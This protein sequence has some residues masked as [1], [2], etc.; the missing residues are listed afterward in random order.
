MVGRGSFRTMDRVAS[1]RGRPKRGVEPRLDRLEG[2]TLMATWINQGPAP[3]FDG[4]DEG[5]VGTGSAANP[6][7]PVSGAV[8]AVAAQPGD[9]N[10]VYVGTTNGGIWKTTNAKATSPTWTPLTDDQISLSTGDIEFSPVDATHQTL[11]VGTG[12]F[13]SD[14]RDGTPG[15]GLLKTTD[16]GTTWTNINP[17]GVFN[18]RFIKS[19]V[20]TSLSGGDVLLVGTFYDGGGVYRSTDGGASFARLSGNGTS[21]LPSAGV[22]ILVPDAFNPSVFYAGVPNSGVYRSDDGGA[23]WAAR[24]VGIAN[25][26]TSNSRVEIT[27]SPAQSGVVFAAILNNGFPR[28]F[29]RSTNSGNTW[30]AMDLAGTNEP[31][32]FEGTNPEGEEGAEEAEMNGD[33]PGG[34]GSIHFAL[35]ADRSNAFVVYASGDRQPDPFPNSVGA[36]NYSGR[37]FRGDA[38]QPL[39]QSKQW[40]AVTNNGANPSGVTAGTSPHADSRD[41]V[42]DADGNILQGNDGGIYRLVN[43]GGTASTRGWTSVVGNLRNTEFISTAYSSLTHTVIGGAQDTGTP[44]QVSTDPN[45]AWSDLLQGDGGVVGVDDLS[46]ANRSIRYTSFQNFGFFNRTTWNASNTLLSQTQVA[47]R[48]P[49]QGN[50]TLFQVDGNIR[51]YQPFELNAIDPTRLVI[52]TANLYESTN[53]GDALTDRTG[54]TG[55]FINGVVYGGRYRGVDSPGLI[56]FGV[57]STIRYRSGDG[58]PITTLSAYPGSSPIDLTVDPQN[59]RRL[60]VLD[61]AQRVWATFNAGASWTNVTGNLQGLAPGGTPSF[62]TIAFVGNSTNYDDAVLAVGGYGGVYSIQSPGLAGTRPVWSKFGEGLSNAVVTDLRYNIPDQVLLA[63][64]LGRGSWTL[65][66]APPQSPGGSGLLRLRPVSGPPG[67]EAPEPVPPTL[68]LDIP[69]VP[70]SPR[71]DRPLVAPTTRQSAAAV[72]RVLPAI[73]SPP[74]G[75]DEVWVAPASLVSLP[76]ASAPTVAVRRKLAADAGSSR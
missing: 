26:G 16:G 22:S 65:N 66:L 30:T 60:F 4:Q 73:A 31:G 68:P 72:D 1:S 74:A 29:Y 67:P 18:G 61:N 23:T 21:G 32:G 17:S 27:A 25:P 13:S 40:A 46:T 43:P 19:V 41:M 39:G 69:I 28:G 49:A 63:G 15:R 47:L 64:T 45:A 2:R 14:A 12:S 59:S 42:Y 8:E 48:L 7:N 62:R 53:R 35:L 51:F 54:F 37:V 76:P 55:F 71:R 33:D 58:Q 9:A 5:I 57:G 6:T 56:Y 11:Y 34:Q 44:Y 36:R 52:P 50:Q 70:P 3:T 10:V 75:G 24:N 20:P 38:S